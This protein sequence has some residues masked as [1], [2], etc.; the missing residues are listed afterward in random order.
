LEDIETGLQLTSRST[1]S[2]A[3]RKMRFVED[4]NDRLSAA[5][6]D[7]PQ[8]TWQ[9][10]QSGRSLSTDKQQRRSAFLTIHKP[11]RRKRG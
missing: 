11:F 6:L 8:L 1:D 4:A 2:L 3:S 7:L 5:R 9:I 10:G